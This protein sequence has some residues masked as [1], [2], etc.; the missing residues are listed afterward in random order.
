MIK[1]TETDRQEKKQKRLRPVTPLI[2]M[3]SG[4]E[5]LQIRGTGMSSRINEKDNLIKNFSHFMKQIIE[6]KNETFLSGDVKVVEYIIA[7]YL[8]ID[9]AEVKEIEKLSIKINSDFS[10]LNQFGENMLN[11]REL[12]LNHSHIS[13]ISDIGTSFKNIKVLQVNDCNL[14]DLSGRN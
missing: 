9:I 2:N 8:N 4:S 5:D 14:V 11:L 7:K 12:K 3:I 6:T 10:L 1:T 13:S